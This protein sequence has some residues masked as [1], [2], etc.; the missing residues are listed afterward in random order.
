M[1]KPSYLSWLRKTAKRGYRYDARHFIEIAKFVD[2]VIAGEITRGRIHM[3]PRHGKSETV[4]IG[5]V[6]WYLKNRPGSRI[7]ITGHNQKFARKLSRNARNAAIM[8]GVILSKERSG[9][10]E[11]ETEPD[12][13]GIVTT[14]TARG[15]GS[16][17]TGEGFDLIIVDDPT[18]DRKQADSFVFRESLWDWFSEGLMTRIQP[19]GV[20]I[21]IWTLWHEDDIA[22]RMDALADEHPEAEQW[23]K[24]VLK[25]IA[26][27]GDPLGRKVGAPLWPEG[28][29]DLKFL[30]AKRLSMDARSFRALYQQ[31]PRP[32]EGSIIKISR[33]NYCEAHEVPKGLRKCRGWDLAFS[34]DGDATA[35]ARLEG[36]DKNGMY[37]ITDMVHVRLST[38]ARNSLIRSTAEMDGKEVTQMIPQDP[39]SAGGD[40]ATLMVQLLAGFPVKTEKVTGKKAVRAQPFA[41]QVEHGNVTIV[42]APW[43]RDCVEELRTFDVNEKGDSIAAHDD[44]VDAISDAFNEIAVPGG[45]GGALDQMIQAEK[46]RIE[47]EKARLGVS[48]S[49][50]N[51]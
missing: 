18:K 12:S 9:A 13:N 19:K 7:L 43:T 28:G 27:D 41:T 45:W 2:R 26:E 40:V 16:V 17:P 35:G 39:G 1:E 5:L 14:V 10:D 33:L 24:L 21:C 25:A 48:G 49:N 31:D 32:R 20:V 30:N 44:R 3:P 50:G 37:Y 11:W 6:V 4:T 34:A 36:P 42:R 47:A 38:G 23:E 51:S 15:V 46:D 29:L 8:N 22:G